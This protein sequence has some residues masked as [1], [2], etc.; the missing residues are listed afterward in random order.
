MWHRNV[1]DTLRQQACRLLVVC[2]PLFCQPRIHPVEVMRQIL[3]ALLELWE[4]GYAHMDIKLKLKLLQT[5][6]D[7]FIMFKFLHLCDKRMVNPDVG[8]LILSTIH[9]IVVVLHAHQRLY[10]CEVIK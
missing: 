5:L 6:D 9:H 10:M 3:H 2:G 7:Y 4:I 8:G 1:N